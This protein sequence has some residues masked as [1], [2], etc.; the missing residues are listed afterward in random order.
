[1]SD[2]LLS[3]E[4]SCAASFNACYSMLHW[5]TERILVLAAAQEACSLCTVQDTQACGVRAAYTAMLT[6]TA[7]M[8]QAL[9]EAHVCQQ[10]IRA[11]R[12]PAADWAEPLPQIMGS[13]LQVAFRL[14]LSPHALLT[15]VR[16]APM[17]VTLSLHEMFWGMVWPCMRPT[18]GGCCA[19][20]KVGMRIH[21]SWET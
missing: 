11:E 3:S 18:W 8:L 20:C 16:P 6:S 21:V 19:L 12:L 14:D 5:H 13:D 2:A 15:A 9:R 1:M 10:G 4:L 17:M 7:D